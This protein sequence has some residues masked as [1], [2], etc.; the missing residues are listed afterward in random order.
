MTTYGRVFGAI[1]CLVMVALI[2]AAILLLASG[3]WWAFTAQ[4]AVTAT[5]AAVYAG[6]R[7]H[8]ERRRMAALGRLLAKSYD[9]N[10]KTIDLD[11]L[12]PIV[13]QVP[14]M[15]A[16]AKARSRREE[17]L[18]QRYANGDCSDY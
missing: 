11:L 1:G 7:L 14:S 5:C 3:Q 15:V 4:V 13:D 10:H 18:A 2:S 6:V 8:R 16:R 12:E 9:M 17:E